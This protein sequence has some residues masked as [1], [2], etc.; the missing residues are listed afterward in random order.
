MHAS[1]WCGNNTETWNKFAD[2]AKI[3]SPTGIVPAPCIYYKHLPMPPASMNRKLYYT[4][5]LFYIW[6]WI[7]ITQSNVFN[8]AD[9]QYAT[10]IRVCCP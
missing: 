6:R 9:W 4:N 2:H 1:I 8:R 3:C 5:F 10:G 7:D